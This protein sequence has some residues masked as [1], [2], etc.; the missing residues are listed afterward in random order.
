MTRRLMPLLILFVLIAAPFGRAQAAPAHMAPAMAT[1]MAGHCDPARPAS[2][3]P[4]HHGASIDC[5]IACAA[6]PAG[7][8]A[9]TPL[10]ALPIAVT[11]P[12]SSVLHGIHPGFDPPP[13]RLS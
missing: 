6:M 4:Y 5:T 1:T 7:D 3:A 2:P 9:Y 13:P 12:L 10:P 8:A 11:A